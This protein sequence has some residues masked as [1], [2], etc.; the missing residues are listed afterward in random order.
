[1]LLKKSLEVKKKK[2]FQPE[3]FSYSGWLKINLS[4]IIKV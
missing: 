4:E 3:G 1:M 2:Q